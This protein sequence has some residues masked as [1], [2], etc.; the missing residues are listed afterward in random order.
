MVLGGFLDYSPKAHLALA[1]T[2]HDCS[3][4]FSIDKPS[5]HYEDSLSRLTVQ[6]AFVSLLTQVK[7]PVAFLRFA[8]LT[9]EIASSSKT[10]ATTDLITI[11]EW[12]NAVITSQAATFDAASDA[13]K[14]LIF[15]QGKL[16]FKIFTAP[17][18]EK[19]GRKVQSSLRDTRTSIVRSL[20]HNQ[21]KSIPFAEFYLKSLLETPA[22]TTD[23]VPRFITIS[24][25]AGAAIDLTATN[26]GIQQVV[27]SEKANI[28][29]VYIQAILG[30]KISFPATVVNAFTPFFSDYMTQED[31]ETTVAPAVSKALLRSP[32]VVLETIIPT[33]FKSISPLIDISPVLASSL[34]NP[35]LSCFSSSN[36]KTRQYSLNTVKIILQ[37]LRAESTQLDKVT[38]AI[39]TPLKTNK[40][41]NADHRILYGEALSALIASDITSKSVYTG[42]TNVVSKEI[43]ESALESLTAAY[44]KHLVFDLQAGTTIEKPIVDVIV[45]GISDKK[46]NLRKIWICTL[47]DSLLELKEASPNVLALLSQITPK[48]IDAWKDVNSNPASAVQNKA[49]AIGLAIVVLASKLKG[50]EAG[51]PFEEAS[52]VSLSLKNPKGSF[53]TSYRTFI[54][55]TEEVDL[56]WAVRALRASAS[57][58]VKLDNDA[59]STEWAL[60]WIFYLNSSPSPVVAKLA[61][62]YFPELYLDHQDFIGALF[63]NTLELL[64]TNKSTSAEETITHVP[65]VRLSS[66]INALFSNVSEDDSLNVDSE[67]LEA[68]VSKLLILSHHKLIA[69]KGGWTSLCLRLSVDP[70][71]LVAANGVKMYENILSSLE[72][73]NTNEDQL[74][75]NACYSAASTLSFVDN[76]LITPLISKTILEGLKITDV[77]LSE[78]DYKIWATPE[79]QLSTE[80][81]SNTNAKKYV[82][83]KNTKDYAEKK[84]EES[85]RKEIASKKGVSG[86]PKKLSKEEQ[87]KHDKQ[88]AEEAA[89]R[90]SLKSFYAKAIHSFGLLD[91]LSDLAMS[92]PDGLDYYF[93]DSV[94][95][96]IK[97]F[98]SPVHK[99]FKGEPAATFL[100]LSNNISDRL[101]PLREFVGIAILRTL[102]VSLDP[103]LTEE[104]LK[105]LVT[106]ILYRIRFLSDQR[107]LDYISL[108]YIVPLALRVIEGRGGV[109]TTVED[110][111]EEQV[112]LSL[113]ILTE[114]AEEFKSEITP[115]GRLINALIVLMQQNPTK[116]KSARDCLNRIV[117]SI[118]FNLN[119]EELDILI[120]ATISKDPLVR[121]TLLELIDD[122]L[123]LSE[124]GYSSELWIEK[125][126]Q[127]QVNV[128]LAN[129][130]WEE[131]ELSI[132][133]ETPAKLIPFLEAEHAPLRRSA[134]AALA[135]AVQ[136][137][138]GSFG[139]VYSALVDLF[140]EKSK[141]PV[142]IKDKFG[143]VVKA[144]FDQPDPSEARNGVAYAF[145]E[146]AP[147]F[148]LETVSKFFSFLI[149]GL[150]LGDK[151]AGVRIEIQ[152]AGMAVIQHHG[153][154]TVETLIPIFEEYLS[155]P[156]T[157]SQVQ[158]NI[159][160][161]VVILYGALAR[162]LQADDPRLL[163][164]VDRLIATLDTPNEDVQFAVSECLPPLVKLFEPELQRYIEFLLNK[165]L[166]G[167]KYAE[168]RGAAY[169]LAG[170]V[171]GAGISALADYDIIRTLTDAV[172]DRRDPKKRQGAQFAFETLSQSLGSFFEPYALEIIPLILASLGDTTPEVR[173]ATT[174]AARQIMKHATGYGI[175]QLIPLALENLNQ[176]AWRGKKGAVELLGTMAYL[177][178]KQLSASLSIIIPELV[179]VLNDTH[180]EVRN[181]ANASLKKFGEVIRN[182][183]IQTLVPDLIKAIG[184]PT[185][186]TEK[187]LDG[188]LK[189]QFVHY[190]DGPSLA[191]V[192]HVLYRGLRDRSA[193][194]KRKACQ[195]V[196]NMSILTDSRDLIPYL[197]TLVA[198]LEVSMVD[199]VPATR[200]TASRA[201]GTLVEK[202]GEDQLPDLI[203]RLLSNL[204]SE[205]KVGDRLGSAQGLAEII[206]GLGTRKLDELLPIILKNCTSPKPFVREGFMPMMIFL[207]ACFGA[208]FSPYL[209]SIIP[210]VLSG[211]A[212]E[213]QSIRENSLKAGRLIVKNYATK[214]VDLLLPEL[215]RGLSDFNYRI[216]IASVELTGDLLYQLTGVSG[217]AELS[218]EDKI[219]YGDVNKTLVDVLG[220]ERRDR[221]FASIFMCR[222]DT[223]GQVRTAA[224]EVWKSLVSN[225]PR[226]VKD[227]LP[228]LTQTI[229]RRLASI[230]EEQRTIAAQ[231]LGEL[232]RR[233]GSTSLSRLL[234]TLEEGM[235][236]SDPDARQGICIAVTE[237]INSTKEDDLEEHQKLIVNVIRTGLGDPDNEVRKA[238]AK[239]FDSLQDA[240]GNSVV[241]QILPDLISMLQSEDTAEN[242]LAALRQIMSAKS[243]VI[244]PVLIPTLLEPPMTISNARSLGALAAVAGSALVKRISAVINALV[245]AI[246]ADEDEA[247]VQESSKALDT[248]LLSINS[249]G[250]VHPLMQHLL[251][252]ARSAESKVRA[253]TFN[254][255]A[256]FF[257]ET[258]LDYSVYTHDWISLGI[259]SLDEV[260][261][262]V[263]K[264]AWTCL[265][266]L[267]KQQSKEELE[268]LVKVTRN[269]LRQTS[270]PGDELPGF[271]L[272]KG[273][274]C[275]LPVF[276][277]GLMYGTSDQREQS[278]LGIADI[279]ERTSAANLKPFV[280]QIT[281]PL[282]RTIGE[283]FPSEVKAAILYT[284]NILLTKIPAFLKPFL[285]QLQ[286]TFA[287]ALSDTSNETLRTRAGKALSTL[288]QL[289]ARV[290][291]LIT[292][293]V[294]GAR[295]A[296]DEGV[297][298]SILKALSDIVVT[299][300]KTLGVPS[301]TL[302]LNFIE[303]QL[304]EADAN[305]Q[306]TLA[307]LVGGLTNAVGD[308]EAEKLITTKV[309]NNDNVKFG[310]LT[311][312]AILRDAATKVKSTGM[313]RAVADF[314]VAN[315]NNSQ[316]EISENA[317]LAAGKFLLSVDEEQKQD[318]ELVIA[319]QFARE[320]AQAMGKTATRSVETR[321]LALV[322]V[323]T[324]ARLQYELVIAENLDVLVPGIFGCVRDTIIP[325][326]LAAEKAYL[327][328]LKL[329]DEGLEGVFEPW[330]A[331]G[332]FSTGPISQRTV[333]EYTKRV[334]LRLA[335]AERERIADGGDTVFSDQVEDEQEIWSIGG[336]ELNNEQEA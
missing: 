88:L 38:L 223:A 53:L 175:K 66:V 172:E 281:G 34:I 303:E 244:F 237:L 282:I 261:N 21:P 249:E 42:I 266:A 49:V 176:T 67:I 333:Q 108:I 293:L 304:V 248:V 111:I 185:Q 75:L 226:M 44:F 260:D 109:G 103:S 329:R 37:T 280:T 207:P 193:G 196:G 141:P 151:N 236:T 125:F 321:R 4:L 294:T 290:D 170:L 209:T 46:L 84:W 308:E 148:D 177:D 36:P 123:E 120:K 215:E 273:P 99:L 69:I 30:S 57:T 291:P 52:V 312:N 234:P 186:Y 8:Q 296:E 20:A 110:E 144:S 41:T 216:R 264:G 54:K 194:V 327:A 198:E 43:N 82:E 171:K 221:I 61:R 28:Y 195:I 298:A 2:G 124:L 311:L 271:A 71:K 168:Q 286:R 210:P 313:T 31:F 257:K 50:Q 239:A 55:L 224:I 96:L 299:T 255:A 160:E 201:I 258:T 252:L 265:S 15:S 217:K 247:V 178:P 147:Q 56:K 68:N 121:T 35:L 325:V 267:I 1:M 48:L 139:K 5:G 235:A 86:K 132:N 131:N 95:A 60:A 262:E 166:T 23:Y 188:L 205:E 242:A 218:E 328:V 183:E 336:I 142:P 128:E 289:Q 189:T 7:D 64:V 213:N 85:V 129:S 324:V 87:A 17:G 167:S 238:A 300:G 197:D 97:L 268:E 169:G 277:Q 269:S 302:L 254:H 203:P 6:N 117:Q 25:L 184:D 314:I 220:V 326:K 292:E 204:K 315:I 331:R 232:V 138:P 165:L 229:I 116:S 192:T 263:V 65:T 51:A 91:A 153:V 180:R 59:I 297:V 102:G 101:I 275:I 283:R 320:L 72:S 270:K 104:P 74:L 77:S 94:T 334:A 202:L 250:G 316:D 22:S 162:H 155:K 45:K 130:I 145:Q 318:A 253:V 322:V 152:R 98:T 285:P 212:D 200:T 16:L 127:E 187:A 330:I 241:D 206:Y 92:F 40:V 11:L 156:S 146:L 276:L 230:D 79:G 14:S 70:G 227:I 272:P 214:A 211:L 317:I 106:R 228:T 10:I 143:M 112:M 225:T 284:L 134:A 78:E 115:R 114:H 24:T 81:F 181:A 335:V 174:Y 157:K 76:K 208:S 159:R 319:D 158:D 100:K 113:E 179:S 323:R 118:S 93:P 119:D 246:V 287:K 47:V 136:A 149:D 39:V 63:I 173:D 163:K 107:P 12:I 80:V 256:T 89:V 307:K 33:L 137:L 154:K 62:D 126:D 245:D 3:G 279:V 233:V 13:V 306:V 305:K 190:I 288:I 310:I 73:L 332:V 161:S 140:L 231:A 164:I 222:T 199:P 9:N 133:D 150:A 135:A 295:A 274:G 301:K 191:L 219:I 29:K 240:L 105:D 278:A 259:S 83:N 58:L 19:R 18:V 32:E 182:P 251:S 309:I 122:E 90:D 27:E 243:G 26:P